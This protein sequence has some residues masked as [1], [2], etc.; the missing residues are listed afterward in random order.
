MKRYMKYFT[1]IILTFFLTGISA[2]NDK[3]IEGDYQKRT[4]LSGDTALNYQIMYPNKFDK[5]K[6]YPLVLFLHGMGE[7]GTNNEKQMTHGSKLFRD[8]IDEYPAIVIFPQCPPTDYWANLYRPDEGGKDRIFE[9]HI[10]E[11]PNP[12]LAAVIKI[13]EEMTS[14]KYVD[15][16]RFYISGLSMGGMGVWELT[17]R[18][19]DKIAASMPICGGGPPEKAIEMTAVPLWVFHGVKDDV[20]DPR[21]S[22]S[23]TKAVQQNGGNAKIS[24]YPNAN[25]NSWDAAFA[26]PKFLTWM[27]SKVRD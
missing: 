16:S 10:N 7:R 8:S 19:G 26:E 18:L 5:S 20:V 13:C 17:W 14:E 22:I 1:T 9:F 11:E 23:M 3:V 6:K 25:H 27:F 15:E 21:M 2:Q 4:Y 24:L 12:S